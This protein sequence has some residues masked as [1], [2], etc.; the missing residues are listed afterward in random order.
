MLLST[1]RLLA[2]ALTLS[3]SALAAISGPFFLTI[4]PEDGSAPY[5][6][7]VA[8]VSRGAQILSSALEY[9][10][11]FTFNSSS[12]RIFKADEPTNGNGPL[13]SGSVLL[14]NSQGGSGSAFEQVTVKG[15]VYLVKKGTGAK[16][17]HSWWSIPTTTG[18]P[19]Q[20][21]YQGVSSDDTNAAIRIDIEA[22]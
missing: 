14:F 19:V 2:A 13:N 1:T 3:T 18:L 22:P 4:V 5:P 15:A 16:S 8:T 9:E 7:T 11:Q 6:A 21:E 20:V 17:I 12:G 10:Q